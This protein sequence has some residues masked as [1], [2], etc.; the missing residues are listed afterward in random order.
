[1]DAIVIHNSVETGA[2]RAVCGLT[3]MFEINE[4]W[5]ARFYFI[6]DV[7]STHLVFILLDSNS[8]THGSVD[9]K[10]IAYTVAWK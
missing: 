5:T 9:F 6:A 7:L 1:M 8:P 3:E 10:K 4:L 2:C